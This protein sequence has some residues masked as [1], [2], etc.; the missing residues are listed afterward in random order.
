[1]KLSVLQ[2]VC[3]LDCPDTCALDITVQDG[4]ML[5]LAGN[6]RHPITRGFACV[7]MAKYPERQ[8]HPERLLTPLKRTGAKGEGRFAP[9]SWEEALQTIAEKVTEAIKKF[10]P[11]SILPYC[12]AG[13][14][15][16]IERDH[17]LAFFR[18]LGAAE[19]DWTICSATAS[20]GWEAN[21]GPEKMST[22]P[23]QVAHSQ[24]ILLWG[25]NVLRS[26]SHLV[27]WLKEARKQGARIVH[28]DPYRN[29]TSRFADEH[30]Q[31][32]VGTDAALALAIGGEILRQ[33]L[34]DRD[35]LETYANDLSD[36]RQACAEWP[37]ARAAEFC[38]LEPQAIAQLACD[39]GG[40]PATFIKIGYGMSRNEGGGNAVRAI[41][42]LPALLGSWKHRGGGGALSTSGAFGLNT[43]R[44]S[45]L[46][47]LHADRPHVNHNELGS[48][49]QAEQNPIST[50][51]VFNSN[52]AAV[53]PDSQSVH[54]GLTRED[55]FTVVLDH[56]QTDT[57]DYADILLP[58]TTFVEHPDLYTAYGHYYL[59]W[60]EAIVPARGEARPNSWVFQQLAARLGLDDEVFR[61][62]TEELARELLDSAHPHVSG[63]RFEQ[64]REQRSIRLNL[65]VD[66]RPYSAGSNFTDRK[67]RF[68]PAPQQIDFQERLS[69]E[70][71]LRL[72]SPPGAYM[73]NTSMGN[74]TSL[75]KAAG[76]EP[77]V[78][79]HP[80]DAS[81]YGVQ[82]GGPIRI[83]SQQG[84]IIRKAIVSTDARQGVVVALGL[85]WPKLSPDRRGLNE[86]TSQR[87][88]DLGG[89]STFGNAVVHIA[90][91]PLP[92]A[93]NSHDGSTT[94]DDL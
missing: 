65:P 11:E 9:I 82:D 33:G 16:L 23:E 27:P 58:A 20:A 18:G 47:L 70:F 26:N 80:D 35:Y 2:S 42:L 49:L 67:I 13:T 88:T 4:R 79:I 1:M 83:T 29:E 6:S 75:I 57:A 14:M 52:P 66:F 37:I 36:Y 7:K 10:G 31:I 40:E 92:V 43:T 61:M 48:A 38:G 34:E 56:F 64:L 91:A 44:Y 28:I 19:L 22:P 85:W 54:R 60:A 32:K 51:F 77:T 46:H 73:L 3:P 50:L 62:S 76:G 5:Q 87:L 25:I 24:L 81:A 93:P 12:Y 94:D 89:G 39:M 84:S 8:Q 78:L 15:G 55:L 71:P 41:T 72:I 30:W 69:P 63:I 53:A 90:P 86:L 21:Y 59:Q 68:T 45:G 17:P 74:L